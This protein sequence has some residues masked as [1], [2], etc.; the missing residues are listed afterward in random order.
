MHGCVGR[1]Q[2]LGSTTPS[3]IYFAFL[4]KRHT[5]VSGS[6]PLPGL[7][8][9]RSCSAFIVLQLAEA[10]RITS[11]LSFNCRKTGLPPSE[12]VSSCYPCCRCD[13]RSGSAS[14][15]FGS[16]LL[17]FFFAMDGRAPLTRAAKYTTSVHH[18]IRRKNGL[19]KHQRGR[20][21]A[22]EPSPTHALYF[23]GCVSCFGAGIAPCCSLVGGTMP[24]IRM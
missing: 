2:K 13:S 8:R 24:F 18:S 23:L 19:A 22:W 5:R 15:S 12:S 6:R 21:R 11:L 20:G 9:P 4:L 1:M 10:G 3:K 16:T 17:A 7:I 14:V